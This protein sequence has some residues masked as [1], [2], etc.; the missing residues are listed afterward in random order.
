MLKSSSLDVAASCP[1]ALAVT[2]PAAAGSYNNKSSPLVLIFLFFASQSTPVTKPRN[3]LIIQLETMRKASKW[4]EKHM[5]IIVLCSSH[6]CTFGNLGLSRD[7]KG[8][9]L[10][11]DCELSR[12]IRICISEIA[13]NI[14]KWTLIDWIRRFT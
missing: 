9:I 5:Q 8:L 14:M 3:V 11:V 1:P 10:R 2:L 12:E 13:I 6:Q 4:R 7:A